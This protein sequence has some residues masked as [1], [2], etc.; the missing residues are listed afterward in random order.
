MRS[1]RHLR[2]IRPPDSSGRVNRGD[3]LGPEREPVFLA[4][5]VPTERG[6][7]GSHAEVSFAIHF[8]SV[9]GARVTPTQATY[10]LTAGTLPPALSLSAQGKV[11]GTFTTAGTYAGLQITATGEDGSTAVSNAFSYVVT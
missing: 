1:Q 5:D 2:E 11:S 7:V 4:F 8:T 6:S 10:R 3:G 9:K